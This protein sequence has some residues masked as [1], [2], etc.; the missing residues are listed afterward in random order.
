MYLI[1]RRIFTTSIFFIILSFH[2]LSQNAD[3][4]T[5]VSTSI[6]NGDLPVPLEDMSSA[7]TGLSRRQGDVSSANIPIGFSFVF[8][9]T[10]YDVFS[11]NSN[12]LIKLGTLSPPTF[13]VSTEYFNDF[14]DVANVPKITAFWDD[15][16]TGDN[17]EILYKL[18]T[19]GSGNHRLFI[20]FRMYYSWGIYSSYNLTYQVWLS[21]NTNEIK[22]VYG[23]G[24]LTANS[25]GM[26]LE[27]LPLRDIWLE[28]T[29]RTIHSHHL[30]KQM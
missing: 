5:V 19:D 30:V 23:A 16:S 20:E 7:L 26:V 18:G 8:E 27:D 6:A 17:G 21:Q 1:S 28:I 9:G 11:V 24:N 14:T 10:S 29:H 25:G 15:I 3:S 12:G 4:Y 22:F 13:P 2:A